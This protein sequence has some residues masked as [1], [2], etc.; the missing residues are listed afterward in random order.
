[1]SACIIARDEAERLPG[2]LESVAFCDEIVVVDSSSEDKTAQLAEAAGARVIHQPWLGFAAQRNVALEHAKG[3][4][5]LEIDADERVSPALRSE[6]EAFLKAPPAG[7]ELGGLPRREVFLGRALGPS[8]KYPMYSHRLLRREAYR[9][10]ELRTVHEG[11]IPHGPVH[12]FEGDL[13][14][15]LAVSW[16]EALTDAWR[17]ARL[18]AGQLDEDPSLAGFLKGAFLR[19]T[20]KFGYRLTV[21]G[22][23]RDGWRGMSRIAI[24]CAIDSTVWI[25]HVLGFRG[26]ERGRSGAPAG[27]H[28]GA[29]KLPRGSAHVVAVAAGTAA[30][31]SA[32]TWLTGIQADG[33]DV[34]LISDS[35]GV[36]T[37]SQI[38]LR[39]LPARG[40]LALIHALDAEEQL[41]T[42][43]AVVPFGR[44]ASTLM[45]LV[46]GPLR[47][48][49]GRLSERDLDTVISRSLS[50]RGVQTA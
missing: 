45:R 32:A 22:G 34:A 19:P 38:R 36:L 27:G 28:Y 41:R 44:R 18:E 43:D 15:L 42:I 17:Y 7:V 37:G 47:G 50:A 25:R 16:R 14:H 24:E 21:D 35:P 5:V 8:A 29:R 39:R 30:T 33:A 48:A 12:P 4:W 46:P 10:D 9:H 31:A 6:I 2:C 40:P 3:R 11:L 1:L 49:L 13:M 20:I 26:R 23:W